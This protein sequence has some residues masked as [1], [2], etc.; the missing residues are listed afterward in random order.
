MRPWLLLHNFAFRVCS[1]W[2]LDSFP[3]NYVTGQDSTGYLNRKLQLST[4]NVH[5]EVNRVPLRPVFGWWAI[6]KR[7]HWQVYEG[8]GPSCAIPEVEVLVGK[9]RLNSLNDHTLIRIVLHSCKHTLKPVVYRM[10]IAAM[11]LMCSCF[12]FYVSCPFI[13]FFL[14]RKQHAL[15]VVFFFFFLIWC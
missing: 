5:S 1:S 12:L 4:T 13:N 6:E 14:K 10:T 15:N 11:K 2:L 9:I 3:V 8:C 7:C